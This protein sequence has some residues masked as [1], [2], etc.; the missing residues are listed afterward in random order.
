MKL[1]LFS[2]LKHKAPISIHSKYRQK[3]YEILIVSQ[4]HC[5]LHWFLV[6]R[7]EHSRCDS[8][9]SIGHTTVVTTLPRETGLKAWQSND[10]NNGARFMAPKS[11]KSTI[12]ATKTPASTN[13]P[14][15]TKCAK[16]VAPTMALTCPVPTRSPSPSSTSSTP[17]ELTV[18]VNGCEGKD[19]GCFD[20]DPD[21]QVKCFDMHDLW[22]MGPLPFLFETIAFGTET[23]FRSLPTG[24]TLLG[25]WVYRTVPHKRIPSPQGLRATLL[26][27]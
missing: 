7:K 11:T 15:S 27:Q 24:W 5:A 18:V 4:S 20:G 3:T 1:P 22:E 19:V 2:S 26:W 16:V 6:H 12:K 13:A 10:T 23:H 8:L 25:Q 14:V 9:G 21:G 17:I